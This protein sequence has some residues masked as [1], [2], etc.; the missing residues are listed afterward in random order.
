MVGEEA[1][2]KRGCHANRAEGFPSYTNKLKREQ[3]QQ[4]NDKQS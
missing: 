1:K 3:Y 4:D 2:W